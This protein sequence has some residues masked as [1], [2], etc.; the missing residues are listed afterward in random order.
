VPVFLDS[1]I[2]LYSISSDPDEFTKR[3][4]ALLLLDRNDC[5]LSVQVLQE[6]Y[7]QATRPSRLRA[8]S[9]ALAED[10]INTWMRFPVQHNTPERSRKRFRSRP[11]RDF[12]FGIARSLPLPAPRIAANS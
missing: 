4:Q 1:N 12:P 11:C 10:F 3:Q 8:L 7:I 6:F 5:A 2:L 9:H